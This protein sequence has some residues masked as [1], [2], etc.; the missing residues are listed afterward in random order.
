MS[1]RKAPMNQSSQIVQIATDGEARASSGT[2]S[3]G[4]DLQHASVIKLVR[5]HRP[6]LEAF[7]GVG[8]EIQPFET[9]GGVQHREVALLNERQTML[10]LTLM[11]NT[12]KVVAFKMQL[13][14]EFCRIAEALRNRDMT[15]WDRRLKFEAKDKASRALGTEGS[16]LMHA[17]RKEKPE[18]NADRLRILE[19]MERPLF[20][21]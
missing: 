7:G 12:Q 21:S 10:L 17:R 13:I 1:K 8:F 16:R 19:E 11:R 14:Q 6:Q 15:M 2:I 3:E 18:L 5:R 20:T 9:Q 4:Y